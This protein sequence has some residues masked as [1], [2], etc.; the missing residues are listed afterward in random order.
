M[1]DSGQGDVFLVGK[2]PPQALTLTQ[3]AAFSPL[4]MDGSSSGRGGGERQ[5][6]F[7]LLA[8]MKLYPE[9]NLWG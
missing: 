4:R 1:V 5:I 9:K 6:N 2:Q 3:R 7:T 8:E